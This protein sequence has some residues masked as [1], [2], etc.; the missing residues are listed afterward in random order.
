MI[1]IHAQAQAFG[2]L[3]GGIEDENSPL[4]AQLTVASVGDEPT[5]TS[6]VFLT[7]DET[8]DLIKLALAGMEI[9]VDGAD[10]ANEMARPLANLYANAAEAL[11]EHDAR[12]NAAT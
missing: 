1:R 8:W 2:F 5:R 9:A 12:A 6:E 10:A 11:A 7:A 4:H 3:L